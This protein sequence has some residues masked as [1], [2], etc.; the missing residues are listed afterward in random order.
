M[1]VFNVHANSQLYVVTCATCSV[2]FGLSDALYRR[3]LEDN[4]TFFCPVGHRNYWSDQTS[5][6][7]RLKAQ[8]VEAEARAEAAHRQREWAESRAKGANIARGRAQAARRRLE[9]RVA[10]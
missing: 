8:L 6:V 3:R 2:E 1:P 10:C 7:E 5:E 9:H 4:D